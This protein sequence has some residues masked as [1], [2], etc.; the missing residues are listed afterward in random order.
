MNTKTAI[1]EWYYWHISKKTKKVIPWVARQLPKR[2]KYY[3]VINGMSYISTQVTPSAIPHEITGFDLLNLW[4]P[5]D[6]RWIRE[7]DQ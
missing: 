1:H 2:I 7:K 3:V 5:N 4:K 6:K